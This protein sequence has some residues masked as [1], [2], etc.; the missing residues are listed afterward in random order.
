MWLAVALVGFV[1]FVIL[2]ATAVYFFI[3]WINHELEGKDLK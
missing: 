3:A 1:V 2:W